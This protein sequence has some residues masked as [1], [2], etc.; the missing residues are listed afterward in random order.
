V[1]IDID[2][3]E[4]GKNYPV[5]LGIIGNAKTILNQLIADLR[6]RSTRQSTSYNKEIRALKT[7][8]TK[9]L[10]AQFP[11]EFKALNGIREVLSRDAIIVG[12][13]TQPVYRAHRCM[14][15]Y[16]PR[17]YFGP[18][19]WAGL[20]FGFP[21]ALGAK[22]GKPSKQVIAMVGDGGFQYNLQ[23][24]AT[25]VQYGI[26]LV[27]IV[28]NDNAWGV[29][30]DIQNDHFNKRFFATELRNPNFSKLAD[31]YGLPSSRVFNGIELA[32]ALDDALRSGLGHLIIVEMPNGFA[33]FPYDNK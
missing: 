9:N 28:F 30:K 11:N 4:I 14:P 3:Q 12:D 20:G 33:N 27:T 22:I 10:M 31:A 21:A 2:P 5:S 1:Q 32:R 7:A 8:I 29:L 13:A 26:N 17:T 16:E 15:I 6:G 24:V 19:S 23:E 25:A 18:N